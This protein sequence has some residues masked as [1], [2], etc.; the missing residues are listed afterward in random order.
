LAPEAAPHSLLVA[1]HAIDIG[2]GE[3]G[4]VPGGGAGKSHGCSLPKAANTWKAK[5]A[6]ARHDPHPVCFANRP[7][8]FRGRYGACCTC[9]A[10]R[11]RGASRFLHLPLKRGGRRGAPGGGQPPAILSIA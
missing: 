3:I 11:E 5:A 4:L 1:R 10:C 6:A 2:G 8:P 7:P 9:S